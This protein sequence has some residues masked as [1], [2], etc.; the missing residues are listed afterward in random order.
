MGFS[1]NHFMIFRNKNQRI[2]VLV[3]VQNLYYSAKNIYKSRINFKGLLELATA[4]RILTRA[5]AYV[6]KS[7][8]AAKESDFFDAISV[9][10]LPN[11]PATKI[12]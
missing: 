5:I 7:D 10:G 9:S 11:C 6:I 1:Y 8:A 3:D 12:P 4:G 2:A